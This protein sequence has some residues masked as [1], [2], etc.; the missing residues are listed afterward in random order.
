LFFEGGS[1]AIGLAGDAIVDV[2]NNGTGDHVYRDSY[3]SAAGTGSSAI[4]LENI[5]N[6]GSQITIEGNREENATYFVR[7][8]SGG[9]NT[10]NNVHISN[11]TGSNSTGYCMYADTGTTVSAS[12]IEGNNCNSATSSFDTLTN[13][14]YLS[15]T[16][17]SVVARTGG[18]GNVLVSPGVSSVFSGFSTSTNVLM[19][20]G[21]VNIPSA[22]LGA[23]T[24]C[25]GGSSATVAL[26][27]T[28]LVCA[29][30][31]DN[32]INGVAISAATLAS[33]AVLT[34]P[35][36]GNFFAGTNASNV[37][38]SGVNQSGWNGNYQ[39]TSVNYSSN[40]ITINLNSSSLTAISGGTP[41]LSL[42]CSN[43]TD[44]TSSYTAFATTVTTSAGAFSVAGKQLQLDLNMLYFSPGNQTN[45]VNYFRLY[46]GSLVIYQSNAKA[47]DQIS[48]NSGTG[49]GAQFQVTA[50]AAAGSSVSMATNNYGPFMPGEPAYFWQNTQNF[51]QPIATNAAITFSAK[52]GWSQTGAGGTI[53]YSSGGTAT[54]TG[55]CLATAS[56]GTPAAVGLIGVSSGTISGTLSF[57]HAAQTT[58][59]GNYTSVPTSWTLTVPTTGGASTCSGTITTTGGSLVGAQ[60][61]AIQLFSLTNVFRN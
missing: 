50:Q 1:S 15:T 24:G 30:G 25:G 48:T 22:V 46:A 61:N 3:F 18:S 56:S 2:V 47:A 32:T 57:G 45:T 16:E 55:N 19:Q 37:T 5:T 58:S 38:I 27:S 11:N 6:V 9:G 4:R 35:N 13:S 23:C 14:R 8:S 59:G 31:S 42:T 26:P 20:N 33:S 29:N 41:L 54:G 44:A 60:G 49:F 7:F 10:Y 12:V 43:S 39:V 34:V 52:T 17:T 51:G 53:T 36:S 21:V 40:A 28:D